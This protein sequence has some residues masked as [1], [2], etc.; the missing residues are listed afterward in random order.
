MWVGI[1]ARLSGAR[2][3]YD[4]HEL[5]PDRNLRPEARRWLM[6]CEALFVRAANAVI[7][8]SPGYAEVLACRYRIPPPTVVRNIPAEL[9]PAP[10]RHAATAGLAVYF[11]ALT[12]SRG[13]E[14]AIAVLSELPGVRLRLVGPDAWG[15]ASQLAD[16]AKRAGVSERVEFRAPVPPDRTG[17]VLWDADVGLALIQPVCLSYELTLPNKLFEYTLAGLPVVATDLPVVGSFVRRH[18]VG[19]TVRPGDRAGLRTTLAELLDPER[20]ASFRRAAERAAHTLRWEDE[21]RALA[22][23]YERVAAR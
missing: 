7:T 6:L 11:G 23:V 16:L 3:I 10:A 13:L 21:S 19:L 18:G 14:D 22:R 20:N 5:W 9:R 2:V 12:R 8:T 4:S 1:V 15:F 17:E